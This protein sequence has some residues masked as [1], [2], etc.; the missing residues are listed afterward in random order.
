MATEA[1]HAIS[2]WDDLRHRLDGDQRCYG[3]FHPALPNEPIVFVE[4]ALTHGLA[5]NLPELLNRDVAIDDA[6]TAI[7]YSIT[8]AQPGLAGVHLGNELI[9]Q[10][11]DELR[12]H[13]DHV[14]TFATLSPLPGFR[15]WLV[16]QVEAGAL[17][18]AELEALGPGARTLVTLADRSW[19]E[20]PT[21]A[22]RV[23]PGILSAAARYLTTVQDG[24]ATDPVANFHLSNGASL[25]RLDW[26]ANPAPYGIEESLG[27]MV[28]YR[29][30]RSKIASNAASYL[31][32]GSV[33]ASGHVR[34]LV[35]TTKL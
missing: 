26:L 16:A 29:Y 22:Y 1:V 12:H 32:D 10:V 8:S 14:R 7:F 34:N 33:S 21:V 23:R 13:A 28:N 17:T 3:F 18:P 31:A 20:D 35:K 4:I 19:L 15:A 24:R 30:D 25:E 2:G 5:D 9:K 27:V 6:D 11:V